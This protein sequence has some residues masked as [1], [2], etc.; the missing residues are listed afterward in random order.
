[1]IAR[2][3]VAPALAA[4]MLAACACEIVAISPHHIVLRIEGPAQQAYDVARAHCATYGKR[5]YLAHDT[6]NM[7]L[8]AFACDN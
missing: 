4:A 6:G 7:H 5:S 3:P 1:M 2:N 8:Y